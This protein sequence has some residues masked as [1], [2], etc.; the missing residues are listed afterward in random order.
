MNQ[1]FWFLKKWRQGLKKKN[2]IIIFFKLQVKIWF[3]NRRMKWRNSKERELLANGGSREQTLP[4]KNNPNPN[5]SDADGDRQKIEYISP[6]PST[7]PQ[8]TEDTDTEDNEDID[9]TR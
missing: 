5:L 6:S 2:I 3:Q 9:V 7:S 4:S 1:T 8:I